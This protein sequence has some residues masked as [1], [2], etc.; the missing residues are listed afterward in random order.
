MFGESCC[1]ESVSVKKKRDLVCL[2]L[3][4]FPRAYKR[5]G[6][7]QKVFF[8]FIIFLILSSP[9]SED[10]ATCNFFK[11]IFKSYF[12]FLVGGSGLA[13]ASRLA[14]GAHEIQGKFWSG[15]QK[16]LLIIIIRLLRQIVD[17]HG[18]SSI[19]KRNFILVFGVIIF[20]AAILLKFQQR[21]LFMIF[22]PM[23]ILTALTKI[24]EQDDVLKSMKSIL[25]H[26]YLAF[27]KVS[28]SKW[29]KYQSEIGPTTIR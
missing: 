9:G 22:W 15:W 25:K 6:C 23:R 7:Y 16:T 2:H 17:C 18:K 28:V 4:L 3:A 27:Q 20:Q 26:I 10:E 5:L 11:T 14:P 21:I 29:Y 12:F 19:K 13:K 8:L 1:K 24:L